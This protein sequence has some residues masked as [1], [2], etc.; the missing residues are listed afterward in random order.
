MPSN[1]LAK[2]RWYIRK[3]E[4]YLKYLKISSN[5]QKKKESV[6]NEINILRTLNH[7]N[8]LKLHQVYETETSYYLILELCRG[9]NLGQKIKNFKQI[10]EN[11]IQPILKGLLK[12]VDYLRINNIIHRDLKIE[13]IL[14]KENLEKETVDNVKIIDF[15]LA[16]HIG[17]NSKPD[18]LFVKCGTPGYIAPEILAASE[19]A[20]YNEKCDVFSLG[21]IFHLM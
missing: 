5:K 9:G 14:F 20:D 1:R 19:T 21:V 8:I 17:Q 16:S 3:K 4:K 15:G 18:K 10:E 13:N 2:K 7:P 12:G 6:F 11:T